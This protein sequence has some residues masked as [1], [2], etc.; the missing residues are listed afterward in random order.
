MNIS[1]YKNYLSSRGNTL[2]QVK[3]TQSD[4]IMNNTF[5]L[6][7]TYKK[8]YILTKEGW[9]WEDAKYQFHSAPSISKD[10]VDYYLQFR[11]KV[12]YPVGSYVIVPD[13]T[14]FDINLSE[15]ERL[16]PFS[17]PVE[18]RTQWW[19]IVGRDEANAY[20][21]YMILKCDW[22]FRWIYKGKMMNCWACSKNANSYTSGIWRDDISM[23]SDNLTSSFIPDTYHV[24]GDKLEKLGLCDTR[25]IFYMQRFFMSNNDLE[26][27]IYQV[28]KITD[29]NP[30]G[31]IKLSIKQDELN[32][33]R[34][35]VELRICDYYTDEG[36]IRL[37]EPTKD[38]ADITKTSE[39]KWMKINEN[40]ELETG[41]ET[42]LTIGQTYY[43]E[44]E[45]SDT[46]IDPQWRIELVD[47]ENIYTE[48]EHSYYIGLMKLT[49]FDK[50]VLALKS[51]KASSL[52]GKEFILSVSDFD[53]EYYSSIKVEVAE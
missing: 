50:S 6:D 43:F 46:D 20:V 47:E 52:K 1:S 40:G 38:E 17:Q 34:D 42:L 12:H 36:D 18:N 3:R 27:K 44:V 49:K 37:D 53:G 19:I 28:T 11:P 14:D 22:D 48:D 51:A 39:I 32:E 10:A 45:F 15:E 4:V 21:R 13:D 26:P 2:G 23:S 25:T 31:I 7:P 35:N 16:N 9:K 29:I 41:I 5:T 33:K 30:Q 24:Y 8:V